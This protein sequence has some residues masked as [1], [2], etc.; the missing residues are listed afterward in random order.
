MEIIKQSGQKVFTVAY[1]SLTRGSHYRAL[2]RTIL[3]FCSGGLLR[4]RATTFRK[5]PRST[6]FPFFSSSLIRDL[7]DITC[8]RDKT[9][10]LRFF[11]MQ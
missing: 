9:G 6:V 10:S 11:Y 4:P 5:R 7:R 1:E 2:T 8:L 3:V